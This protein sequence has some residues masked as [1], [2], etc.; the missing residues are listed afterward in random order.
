V[1]YLQIIDING[2]DVLGALPAHEVTK[3]HIA[4]LIIPIIPVQAPRITLAAVEF[5]IDA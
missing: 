3:F 5:G 1:P 2:C 4:I